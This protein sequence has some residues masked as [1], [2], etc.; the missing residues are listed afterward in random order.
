M[1]LHITC[2]NH[3][4]QT[5]AIKSYVNKKIAVIN[6]RFQHITTV[7]VVLHIDKLEHCAEANVHMNGH[8]VFAS[9]KGSDLYE[10]ID[11]LSDK[12]FTQLTKLKERQIDAHH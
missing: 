11:K 4:E 1:E 6:E 3:L 7:N 2:T 12:L 10:A 5:D 9:A 8:D